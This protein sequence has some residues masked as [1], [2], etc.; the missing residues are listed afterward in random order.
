MDTILFDLDGTLL[1]M[2]TSLFTKIYF[3]EMGIMFRDIIDPTELISHIW[4]ST[5]VMVKN[6]ELKLNEEVFMED[7]SKRIQTDLEIFKNR[8]DKFYDTT[9]FNAR[10]AVKELPSISEA[11][12]ILKSKGYNMVI[13]TNPLFPAKAILHRIKWAGL[14]PSDFIYISSYERNHF[15]KP[16]V[17]FYE[18]ILYSINKAPDECIMVGN[19]VQEDLVAG[20]LGIKTFL[21]K[22]NIIHRTDEQITADYIGYY[23]DFLSYVRDLPIAN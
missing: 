18:E 11:V 8:F 10:S 3:H 4:S 17:K 22:D 14:N 13:A 20:K 23:D 12:R 15:C 2:D 21:I 1:P 9:F 5:E 16:Q 6:T 7:F 19:D